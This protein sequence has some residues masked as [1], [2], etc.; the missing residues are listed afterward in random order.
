MNSYNE[1]KK[2]YWLYILYAVVLAFV[3]FLFLNVL[4]KALV[5]I[6]GVFLKY[7]WGALILLVLVLLVRKRRNKKK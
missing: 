3:C 1:K 7:W 2:D 6:F 5:I 4:A